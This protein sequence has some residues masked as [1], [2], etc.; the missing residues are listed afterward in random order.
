MHHRV[1]LHLRATRERG[2][3]DGDAGGVGLAEARGHRLV[4]LREVREVREVDRDPH[5]V[6][7][8]AACLAAH[9]LEVVEDAIDLGL[10][11]C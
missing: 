2:D 3:A 9:G 10:E 5:H 7:E 11:T 1:D 6:V 8:T 4:H